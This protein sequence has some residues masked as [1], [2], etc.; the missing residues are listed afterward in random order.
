MRAGRSDTHTGVGPAGAT[1]CPNRRS[2]LCQAPSLRHRAAPLAEAAAARKR[3]RCPRVRQQGGDVLR[4][5]PRP[6]PGPAGVVRVTGLGPRPLAT[7]TAP[8]SRRGTPAPRQRPPPLRVSP[9]ACAPPALCARAKAGRPVGG[10]AWRPPSGSSTGPRGVS[11]CGPRA[12]PHAWPSSRK[13]SS[14]R[15]PPGCSPPRRAHTG[16]PGSAPARTSETPR[17]PT[18]GGASRW[19]DHGATLATQGGGG[20]LSR[21]PSRRWAVRSTRS[22]SAMGPAWCTALTGRPR[23]PN[24]RASH[25]RATG[26]RRLRTTGHKGLPPRTRH[27]HGA[28]ALLPHPPTAAP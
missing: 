18:R 10:R 7:P 13:G 9:N 25:C 4:P 1:G 12:R 14:R 17:P 23:T 15:W 24:A 21:H 28:C 20:P 6:A 27:R 2:Q 11:T 16:P 5:E 19:R 8:A 22:A 26:R 3:E